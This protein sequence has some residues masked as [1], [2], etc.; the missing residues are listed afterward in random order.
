MSIFLN[1][2]IPKLPAPRDENLSKGILETVDMDSYRVEKQTAQRLTLADEDRQ[3]E[4]VPLEGG[5][6]RSEPELERLS[7]I[8]QSFNDLFGNIDWA[9]S[10]RIRKLIT[11]EIPQRA[12]ADEA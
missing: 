9:D 3:I 12:A 7:A 4:P 8:I 5:G 11:E 2:L 1:F 6:Q 10:D